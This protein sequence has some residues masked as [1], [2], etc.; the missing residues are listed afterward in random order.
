MNTCGNPKQKVKSTVEKKV[1]KEGA[2]KMNRNVLAFILVLL[3]S[4]GAAAAEARQGNLEI[5]ADASRVEIGN[6][7]SVG[8]ALGIL[9]S[10]KGE[11]CVKMR[12]E[13]DYAG[14]YGKLSASEF[15]LSPNQGTRVALAIRSEDYAEEG[16]YT[17]TVHAEYGCREGA[18][19]AEKTIEVLVNRG[20]GIWLSA[21]PR[22][23]FCNTGYAKKIPVHVR[24]NSNYSRKITLSASSARFLPV[25]EPNEIWLDAGEQMEAELLVHINSTT[26]A[27]FYSIPMFADSEGLRA[28]GNAEFEITE[29]EKPKPF[30]LEI[31]D[32]YV[33]VRKGDEVKLRFRVENL[34]KEGQRITLSS[35]GGLPNETD[36]REIALEGGESHYGEIT[37]SA[38]EDESHG[39]YPITLYAWNENGEESREATVN[40]RKE[41]GIRVSIL[42]NGIEQR[43]CSASEFGVF[44]ARVTNHGDYG[45]KVRLYVEN[46]Y[47]DVSHNVS[48]SKFTLKAGEGRTV[49]ISVLPGYDAEPGE[50]TIYLRVKAGG[51]EEEYALRF[52][53]IAA[54]K[55][56]G[57]SAGTGAYT[58]ESGGSGNADSGSGKGAGA[59]SSGG[60]G[61]AGTIPA[62]STLSG[63]FGGGIT[64][65]GLIILMLL[66]IIYLVLLLKSNKNYAKDYTPRRVLVRKGAGC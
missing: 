66:V 58:A 13:S 17:I 38:G 19:S 44:E 29:C 47:G 15:C 49:Q 14:V 50:R 21:E 45:E 56:N 24:N 23:E 65:L 35:T 46:P 51:F 60:A 34:L 63:A 18:C 22:M 52:R 28:A 10:G 6:S 57:G 39:E 3:L 2:W 53:V 16:T 27:G 25:F 37:V 41:H 9:N 43:P 33:N 12:A 40:V 62:G 32:S 64:T 1:G 61:K 11:V 31:Y 36:S 5:S 54:G 42:N 7:D 30:E 26:R 8:I 4:A 20:G 59:F 48:E 55:E